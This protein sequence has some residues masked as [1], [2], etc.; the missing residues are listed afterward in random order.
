MKRIFAYAQPQ[1]KVNRFAV[2]TTHTTGQPSAYRVLIVDDAPA[3]RESLRWAFDDTPDLIVVGEAGDGIE[4]IDRAYELE[5][6][7]VILDIELPRLDGYAVA[8]WL[9]HS[10]RPPVVVFL[11][12]H[13]DSISRRRGAEAGGDGF[14]EKGIGWSA[15]IGQIRQALAGRRHPGGDSQ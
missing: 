5:P 13:S 8:R 3:V 14:A 12:I 7:V 1:T 4:A 9:K 6:D 2:A 15:L 11:T 10:A